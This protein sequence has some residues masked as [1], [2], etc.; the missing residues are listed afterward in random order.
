MAGAVA[1]QVVFEFDIQQPVHA[2]DA[3]MAANTGGKALD[4]TRRRRDEIARLE[5][6]AVMMFD[7]GADLDESFD[8]GKARRAGI[9]SIR[10]DPVGVAGS[11]VRARLDASVAFLDGGFRRQFGV[12][13]GVEMALSHCRSDHRL[14]LICRDE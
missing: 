13:R 3:P 14:R 2:L 12:G 9:A 5:A 6:A 10:Y 7:A 8:F 11:R 1:A 4:I